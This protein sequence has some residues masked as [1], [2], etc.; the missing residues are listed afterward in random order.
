[1]KRLGKNLIEQY[2]KNHG[3]CRKLG[4]HLNFKYC[5]GENNGQACTKILDCWFE[6]FDVQKFM[7]ENFPGNGIPE[8]SG[9][10]R[11]KTLTILEL[12]QEA[13]SRQQSI[14]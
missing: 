13:Q 1:M 10:S 14:K 2:D 7:N 12:I 6:I 11:P 8:T 5:R 4:H 3:Y 9:S